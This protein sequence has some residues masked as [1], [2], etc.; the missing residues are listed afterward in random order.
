MATAPARRDTAR[1]MSQ[2]NVELVREGWE[3]W[4]R[5]D[6]DALAATWDPEVV[7]DTKHFRDWPE[8]AYRGVEGVMRFLTEWLEVWG[9]YE[10]DVDDVLAAPDGRVVS[11][12]RQRGKGRHSGLAMTLDM[13]Q[14]ATIRDG[15]IIRFD[16]YD[17]REEAIEAAGL[18]D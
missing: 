17:N 16:N 15:K 6:M 2:E 10:V 3:A 8:S 14:I 11:L 4:F 12:I 5:G 13:A 7:W 9:D 18:S 1:A